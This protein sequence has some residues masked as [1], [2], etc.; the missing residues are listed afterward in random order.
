MLCSPT[1]SSLLSQGAPRAAGSSKAYSR[2]GL[3]TCPSP[4]VFSTHAQLRMIQA[5]PCDER[6]GILLLTSCTRPTSPRPQN[7]TDAGTRSW[8]RLG[9]EVLEVP[10]MAERHLSV[11]GLQCTWP[12]DQRED[13]KGPQLSEAGP[14]FLRSPVTG[15]LRHPQGPGPAGGKARVTSETHET[16]HHQP[17]AP[18]RGRA[19]PLSCER[20][21]V[22]TQMGELHPN[23]YRLGNHLAGADGS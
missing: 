14:P 1:C 23:F 8:E 16:R 4:S 21:W 9:G 15:P 22:P 10:L 6:C 18:H 20:C 19:L 7:T 17:Q 12:W 3:K 2:K 5:D 11:Q 13:H